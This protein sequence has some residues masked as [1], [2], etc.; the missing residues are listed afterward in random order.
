MS[1]AGQGQRIRSVEVVYQPHPQK[2]L[3]TIG[4]VLADA[5]A[6]ADSPNCQGS[7]LKISKCLTFPIA[8]ELCMFT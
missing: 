4:V 8:N 3:N 5:V 6:A 1:S 2:S 7:H